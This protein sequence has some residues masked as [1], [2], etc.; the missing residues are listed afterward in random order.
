MKSVISPTYRAPQVPNG[1]D[2]GA[3]SGETPAAVRRALLV[4]KTQE[5]VANLQARAKP[6]W[7]SVALPNPASSVECTAPVDQDRLTPLGITSN[8]RWT[9]EELA[10]VRDTVEKARPDLE[11]VGDPWFSMFESNYYPTQTLHVVVKRP[12]LFAQAVAAHVDDALPAIRAA[13][14]Q[15]IFQPR[16]VQVRATT[17]PYAARVCVVVPT[18]HGDD[19]QDLWRNGRAHAEVL[20]RL[21]PLGLRLREYLVETSVGTAATVVLSLV[22][23]D[24]GRA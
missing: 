9:K 17:F 7:L 11:I 15:V 22:V 24:A 6:G 1:V 13:V 10:Y 14:Q 18:G 21:K 2:V 3:A 4:E 8:A 23:Q 19:G 20:E 16:G 12:D 5:L